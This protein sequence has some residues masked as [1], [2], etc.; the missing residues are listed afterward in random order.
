MAVKV[1]GCALY[2]AKQRAAVACFFVCP[3]LQAS[4]TPAGKEG[5]EIDAGQNG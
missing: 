1:D 5:G 4:A 3:L 2:G